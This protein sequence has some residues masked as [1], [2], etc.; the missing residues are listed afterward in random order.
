MKPSEATAPVA[1]EAAP[2]RPSA[3]VIPLRRNREETAFLPAALEIVETPPPPLGR[4]IGATIIAFFCAALAWSYLGK[5][6][7]IA[8]APGKVAPFGQVKIVQPLESGVVTAIHVNDGDRVA[9]GQVLIELDG[10][11]AKAERDKI[12][13]DLLEA[14]LDTAQLQALKAGLG[15]ADPLGAFVPPD[16][17]PQILVERTRADLAAR[18]AE[19]AAKLAT[20]DQQIAQKKAEGDEIAA[21]VAKLQASTPILAEQVEVRRQ[22][23]Q[24]QFGNKLA[25]LEVEQRLVEQQHET[26]VQ[27]HRQAEIETARTALQRQYQ[28]A[29]AEYARGIYDDLAQAEQTAADQAQDLIKAESRLEEARLTAPIDGTVQQLAVHTVGGVVTPAQA[30]LVV[31]PENHQLEIEAMVQNRDVGFVHEGQAVE[32]KVETFNF[33]RYGL[34]HGTVESVSRDAVAQDQRKRQ[35]DPSADGHAES[36]SEPSA[37]PA[38]VA[39]I[40][41]DESA[42]LVDGKPEPL[43]PGMAVQAEIKTGRRRVIDYLL[44]PLREYS[45]EALRER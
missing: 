14:R 39:R 44:S 27:Q 29:Q 4:A 42:V 15:G 37:E 43:G 45:H 12:A 20:L 17:A 10:R 11:T 26:I 31:V 13:H 24:I 21:T 34:L 30:L 28:Q 38:Y 35:D 8:T 41:L 2:K 22:A 36:G 25:Y 19:Q 6:D 5:V 33:T 7:I 23:M 32:I 18:A 1:D 3:K 40:R 16:G 9:A